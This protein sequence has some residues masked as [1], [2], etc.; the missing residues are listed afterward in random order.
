MPN[1]KVKN[2]DD[3]NFE[4]EVFGEST[5]VLVQFWASW[6]PPCSQVSPVV[7]RI[8]DEFNQQIIVGRLDIENSQRMTRLYNVT[9]VPTL[10][11]FQSGVEVYRKMG[12]IN[13]S[14]L[15]YLIHSYL[16]T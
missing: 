1:D 11:L 13:E 12:V 5:K 6:S 16:E 9:Q 2:L 14:T 7:D 4:V 8:A 3:A 10:I 15:S